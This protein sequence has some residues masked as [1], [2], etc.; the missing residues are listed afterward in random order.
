[1]V[2]S[3]FPFIGA[4]RQPRKK[5]VF[6]RAWACAV[7]LYSFEP[8]SMTIKSFHGDELALERFLLRLGEGWL[9]DASR[10][11]RGS[12]EA[13]GEFVVESMAA[14][15]TNELVRNPACETVDSGRCCTCA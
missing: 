2:L 8:A 9:N 1:M 13:M 3:A 15:M 14:S 10:D 11:G 12:F 5:G 6:L 7:S 4:S